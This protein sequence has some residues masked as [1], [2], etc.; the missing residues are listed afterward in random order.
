MALGGR[1]KRLKG[2]NAELE[3]VHL[4][5]NHGFKSA[6]RTAPMQAGGK[7]Y[8]DVE[9]LPGFHV[10]V[11]RQERWRVRN[12][13][14]QAHEDAPPGAIPLVFMRESRQDWLVVIDATDFLRVITGEKP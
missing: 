5:R 10:E 12:W 3:V 2:K 14:E 7:G 1:G 4:L 8:G 13:Y 9:G 6:E 11:K